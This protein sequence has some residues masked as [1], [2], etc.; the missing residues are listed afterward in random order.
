MSDTAGLLMAKKRWAMLVGRKAFTSS[1]TSERCTRQS[2]SWRLSSHSDPLTRKRNGQRD[3]YRSMAMT[4]FLYATEPYTLG[5]L[6][7]AIENPR[8]DDVLTLLQQADEF[9]LS[10]YPAENYHQ[11]VR[12]A[13]VMP[14]RASCSSAAGFPTAT[15][16]SR[17]PRL[18]VCRP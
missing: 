1:V 4:I 18:S 9:A 2:R 13:S 14:A 11:L 5:V 17:L 12:S 3:T 16:P 6:T 8:Q 10:L 7:I 15:A